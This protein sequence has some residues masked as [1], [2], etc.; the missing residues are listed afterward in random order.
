MSS[1]QVQWFPGHMAKALRLIEEELKRVDMVIE[2]RDARA[3][4][5]TRNP[6]LDK[7]LM[8]KPR[9]I[10]LTKRDL[11]QEAMSQL[12]QN[13]LEEE[14]SSVLCVDVHKDPIKRLVNDKVVAMMAAKRERDLRRG[15][16]PRIVVALIVGVPNVGK[17]TIINKLAMRKAS[18]VANR[19]GVTQ[20]L[21]RVKVNDDLELVDTPGV[22]WPKFESETM[23]I[24]CAL[25]ASIKATGFPLDRVT[26]YARDFLLG[27]QLE[28]LKSYYRVDKF[29]D[30]YKDI[31]LSRG[32]WRQGEPD[33][34]AARE[35]F[36]QDVQNCR[37]GPITWDQ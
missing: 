7:T 31:A 2:C 24:H 8:N 32:L 16:R 37:M 34:E 12:W 9:L 1:R 35:I 13:R 20:S 28:N 19:P 14:G 22:L 10:L 3:P 29:E 4:Q 25:V 26:D 36:L 27:K 6:V 33:L 30:F 5:S 18:P 17:S 23:G 15:I 21:Q 11:A